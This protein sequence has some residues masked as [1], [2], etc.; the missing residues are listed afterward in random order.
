MTLLIVPPDPAWPAQFAE[1]SRRLSKVLEALPHVWHH[2]GS[3]AVPGL[4][5]KPI[6][7]MLLLVPDLAALQARSGLLV[8]AGY[9]AM[10]EYGIPQ[11]CYFRR[12]TPQG[13][14]T[15][16]LHAFESGHPAALRHLALRD[17]LDAHP[18]AAHEYA[19]LKCRLARLH[20]DDAGA[21]VAGKDAFVQQQTAL[22]LAWRA[23]ASPGA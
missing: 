9:E 11:R 5:A 12:T 20:P 22:A 10:G 15:H 8:A 1:E 14:R 3:T 17:Y 18:A 19:A 21:Y 23:R 7:D 2:I 16:H 13:L 6:I 4:H